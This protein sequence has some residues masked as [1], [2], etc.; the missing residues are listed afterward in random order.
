MTG[1]SESETSRVHRVVV[2]KG[3]GIG[4]ELVDAALEVLAAVEHRCGNFHLA[5]SSTRPAPASTASW[6]ASP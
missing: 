1:G 5:L 4:P 3:D 6:S 2:L